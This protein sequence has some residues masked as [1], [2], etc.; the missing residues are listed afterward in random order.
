MSMSALLTLPRE[1][2][3]EIYSY[4][5]P[6]T[7][8]S[9]PFKHSPISS[10]SHQPP[11]SALQCVCRFLHTDITAYFYTTATLRFVVQAFQPVYNEEHYAAC[12]RAIC[13]ARRVEVV[14]VWS[15]DAQHAEVD[16]EPWSCRLQTSLRRTVRLLM[17]EA[18]CLEV[19]V[20]SVRDAG[21]EWHVKDSIVAPLGDLVGGVS[22]VVGEVVAGERQEQEWREWLNNLL[23]KLNSMHV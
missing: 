9:Y 1:L 6:S 7:P 13:L 18:E 10:I 11:S 20:V 2:R 15:T 21:D 5:T 12:L 17:D 3:F 14:L 22:M 16:G 23:G 4:L 8:L 19:L